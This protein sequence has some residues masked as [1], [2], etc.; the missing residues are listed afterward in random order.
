MS[1][2]T[3]KHCEPDDASSKHRQANRATRTYPSTY[4]A[5]SG[6]VR[7]HDRCGTVGKIYTDL[8]VAVPRNDLSSLH[9]VGTGVAPNLGMQTVRYDPALQED[10]RSYGFSNAA[11]SSYQLTIDRNNVV[12]TT[13]VNFTFGPPYNPLLAPPI[14][15]MN[16]DPEWRK[17]QYWESYGGDFGPLDGVYD[18]PRTLNPADATVPLA[19]PAGATTASDPQG[20][21]GPLAQTG[22]Q[23]TP[24]A[25][26][27]TSR[28]PNSS[29]QLG[30]AKG[31]PKATC[32]GIC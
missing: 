31:S 26:Q 30:P 10:C 29:N 3:E 15:L 1:S 20:T 13:E 4:L 14:E 27:P 28:D 11:I 7:V 16:Y 24:N 2:W 12:P 8:T 25:P 32:T 5:I 23:S 19:T 17:C 21:F 6:S 9:F 22:A 18:P